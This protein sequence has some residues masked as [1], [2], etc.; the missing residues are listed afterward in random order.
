ML[1]PR[2]PCWG[3]YDPFVGRR[4]VREYQSASSEFNHTDPR[5]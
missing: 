1:L 4:V 3:Q 2:R 5:R